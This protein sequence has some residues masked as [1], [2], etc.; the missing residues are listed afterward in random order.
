MSVL[1]RM[2]SPVVRD[3]WIGRTYLH[4]VDQGPAKLSR[5]EPLGVEMR[6]LT[7]DD[8]PRLSRS[9]DPSM[10]HR[11]RAARP[12]VRGFAAWIHDVPVA[13]CSFAFGDEY[14]K[15][16]GFYDL[17]SSEAELADVY[18][19][20]ECRGRGIATALIRFST[21]RMHD[22]GFETLF[23]KVWHSNASS[24]RAILSAGWIQSCFFIRL[25]PRGTDRSWHAE[26][27][28]P[29]SRSL[30]RCKSTL[31]ASR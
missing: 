19:A 4:R 23:A 6:L 1:Q 9:S 17:A 10:R 11:F 14:R 25:Y 5:D 18:T 2:M 29:Q 16:E 31:L 30:T 27:R 3:F 24:S 21:E 26:W 13:I 28:C 15:S 22:H 8:I 12:G 7:A 20:S